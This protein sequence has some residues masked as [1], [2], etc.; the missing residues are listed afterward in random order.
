MSATVTD[1]GS[2]R[3]RRCMRALALRMGMPRSVAEKLAN[4]AVRLGAR[5]ADYLRL[6]CAS[7]DD[8]R[9][10]IRQNDAPG[11]DDPGNDAP[12]GAA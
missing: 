9:E 5:R 4:I 2:Y 12:Q 10:L 6:G 7:V 8:L 11:D 1:I 3:A